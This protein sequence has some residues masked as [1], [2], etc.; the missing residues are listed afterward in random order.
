MA[1]IAVQV[2]AGVGAAVQLLV[3]R[4]VL[5]EMF[6]PGDGTAGLLPDLAL[7]AAVATSFLV[8][9]QLQAGL[10][11]L[12]TERTVRYV[13]RL[14]IRR[15]NEVDLE[16]YELPPFY[17]GLQRAQDQGLLAPLRIV[18][19]VALL[20][21]SLVGSVALLAALATLEPLLLPLVLAGYVPLW[22]AGARN[23]AALYQFSYGNTPTDRAR[24]SLQRV[25]TG[26]D[27]AKEVR[28][29]DLAGF[30]GER[31]ERLFEGRLREVRGL[32]RT[33]LVRSLRASAVSGLF[34]AVTLGL[35]AV[36][37][38]RG[39]LDPAS[40]VAAALAVQQLG[41]RLEAAGT[42]AA[43][44]YES[45]MFLD[46]LDVFLTPRET[47]LP[48]PHG[49]APA[50]FDRLVARDLRYAYPGAARP[51]LDGVDVEVRAGEVVALVGENGAGKTTL[52]KLLCGLYRPT[53]GTV[54]WDGVDLAGVDP[55][56]V[57]ERV[58]VVFQDF[59]RLPLTAYENVAAGRPAAASDA[60]RVRA[61]ARAAGVD[62]AFAG[63]PAGYD[64]PLTR[65]FDGG[66]E[67]SGG[68]WQRVALARA[69][70]RDAPFVVLDEPTA[71]LDPR[72]E[73]ALFD[74][75]RSLYAGRAVLLVSHRFSSVR[76]A[77]RIYV[78]DAGRVVEA[79]THDEL[80][81]AG[82]RYAEM[83]ALQSSAYLDPAIS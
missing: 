50:R 5:A 51:A 64:T 2:F 71:A 46:D 25:L 10:T 13:Q 15:A 21:S 68:Q 28:A 16:T 65:E 47:P 11:R 56:T 61:A 69:F 83:F 72:A 76:A 67:L 1:V 74:S 31:W 39:R 80:M 36:L 27:S 33:S 43:T 12:L 19:G 60:G 49:V 17:D 9:N 34:L 3:M 59:A 24:L 77:D 78:L 35:L 57:R 82:G 18:G 44:L 38:D 42:S 75:V 23:S 41:A 63:L 8:A 30:L 37:L 48:V 22:R 14:V 55:A 73:R 32:V 54:T 7:L 52:A 62:A 79:G 20:V 45:S 4:R 53:G 66:S 70:F 40:A 58:A 81:A 6:A 29:F 26:R